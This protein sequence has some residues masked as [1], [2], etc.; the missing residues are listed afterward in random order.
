MKVQNKF[1][2]QYSDTR[3]QQI[4]WHAFKKIVLN[5][6]RFLRGAPF[7]QTRSATL[8]PNSQV[9]WN[10]SIS[11]KIR[12]SLHT[13]ETFEQTHPKFERSVVRVPRIREMKRVLSRIV[14]RVA[15]QKHNHVLCLC[16]RG[17]KLS[18]V[19]APRA[20]L[21][22]FPLAETGWEH[23]ADE[24]PPSPEYKCSVEDTLT[25]LMEIHQL[26]KSESS[27]YHLEQA[28]LGARHSASH[29]TCYLCGREKFLN[30]LCQFCALVPSEQIWIRLRT[31]HLPSIL[32]MIMRCSIGTLWTSRK[33]SVFK[34]L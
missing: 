12:G 4:W 8:I 5:V 29:H 16:P 6:Q 10:F 9:P 33:S 34:G 1:W 24:Q 11:L 2:F 21:S 14:E 30:E 19:S 26:G 25:K 3:A 20:Q 7:T 27:F 31:R 17:R 18:S 23:Y 13:R 32:A 22:T 15:L 28:V